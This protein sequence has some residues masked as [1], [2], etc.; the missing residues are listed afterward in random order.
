[1]DL[2]RF[3]P[4]WEKYD[5]SNDSV[6]IETNFNFSFNKTE[7]I[8]KCATNLTFIQENQPFLKSELQTFYEITK[9]SVEGLTSENVITIPRG[10]LCQFASLA[11]GS[12]R[13]IIHMKTINTDLCNLILPPLYLDEVIKGD[14]KIPLK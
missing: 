12:F 7:R 11:Y 6:G 9:E 1:M 10:L 4:E 13:G 2:T 3:S 8:L 5:S 14:M